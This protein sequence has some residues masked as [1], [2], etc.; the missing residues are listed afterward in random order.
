VYPLTTYNF[1]TKENNCQTSYSIL[2]ISASLN[3][4]NLPVLSN[5]TCHKYQSNSGVY[6][7]FVA[8]LSGVS[9]GLIL[10]A[11]IS[12]VSPF[13]VRPVTFTLSPIWKLAIATPPKYSIVLYHG[14]I[15]YKEQE[16]KTAI[17]AKMLKKEHFYGG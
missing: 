2:C 15:N 14:F 1:G 3:V 17:L 5:F 10:L 12:P 13:P 8:I 16:A 7:I 11:V 9:L 6:C 4:C